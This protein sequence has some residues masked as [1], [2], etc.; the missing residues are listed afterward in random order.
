MGLSADLLQ[1]GPVP[2]RTLELVIGDNRRLRFVIRP[3]GGDA[4]LI[5]SS[6]VTAHFQAR[7]APN[8]DTAAITKTGTIDTGDGSITFDLIPA[9]TS[10]ITLTTEQQAQTAIQWGFYDIEIRKDGD[11]KTIVNGPIKLIQQITR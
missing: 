5:G 4:Y 6:G 9:D 7:T 8:A 3:K 2:A 1:L 10:G 11:V